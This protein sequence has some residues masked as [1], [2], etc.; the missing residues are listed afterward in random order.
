M[1][2]TKEQDKTKFIWYKLKP[3]AG[4]PAGS[5]TYKKFIW[6]FEEGTL[7][8][9]I[10]LAWDL[11]EIWGQNSIQGPTDWVSTIRALFKGETLTAFDIALKDARQDI[12]PDVPA[13]PIS[14]C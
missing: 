6:I 12:D 8:Q 4:Q 2:P 13:H 14:M 9:W 7:Q 5:T 3:R 11:K 1:L 10:N